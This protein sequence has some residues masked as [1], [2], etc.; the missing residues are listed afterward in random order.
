MVTQGPD[1]S[2]SLGTL[3]RH[4]RADPA[5]LLVLVKPLPTSPRITLNQGDRDTGDGQSHEH[6]PPGQVGKHKDGKVSA[7][8]GER[9]K[10]P[11][12]A[13]R[14]GLSPHCSWLQQLFRE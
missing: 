4:T 10:E 13:C 5:K 2:P 7:I 9:D 12:S 3:P 1:V 8:R 6:V 14:L 11:A